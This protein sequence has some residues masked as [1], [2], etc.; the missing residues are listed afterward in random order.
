MPSTPLLGIGRLEILLDPCNDASS[1]AM[2]GTLHPSP[3]SPPR[4]K[5]NGSGPLSGA[6]NTSCPKLY[7]VP[8]VPA[9][10]AASRCA[11]RGLN[12]ARWGHS[13]LGP[14]ST[15]RETRRRLRFLLLARSSLP[16]LPVGKR[17]PAAVASVRD[18]QAAT[19]ASHPRHGTAK[20]RRAETAPTESEM[21][22]GPSALPRVPH[23]RSKWAGQGSNLRHPACKASALPTELPARAGRRRG[24][25]ARGGLARAVR[26]T[27][28]ARERR[29]AG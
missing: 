15:L 18:E 9:G 1:L 4:G 17:K 16:T 23:H 5:A 10:F 8:P 7:L 29:L 13:A 12:P 19:G 6:T 20:P 25:W 27:C 14:S 11:M 22:R 2:P 3:K 26:R 28:S 21:S 24:R